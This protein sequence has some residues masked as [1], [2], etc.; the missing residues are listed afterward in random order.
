MLSSTHMQLPTVTQIYGLL[1]ERCNL[2]M[3][4]FFPQVTLPILVSAIKY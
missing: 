2:Y 4:S 3:L 1:V